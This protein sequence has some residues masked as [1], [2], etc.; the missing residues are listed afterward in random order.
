MKKSILTMT[1]L[2]F[3]MGAMLTGCNSPEQK[4]TNA[5]DDVEAANEALDQ[6]QA[7]YLADMEQFRKEAEAQTISND[8]MIAEFKSRAANEKAAVRAEYD[9]KIAD[10]EESNA[11]MK[12]RMADYRD[13]GSDNWQ[14][15][16]REFSR[17]MNELGEA[18]AN[19]TKSSTK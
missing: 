7:E 10:L 6:A 12:R 11:R 15:F 19:F 1:A 16:K 2:I 4:L 8:Q 5:E 18:I 3:I 17:D 14:E 13:E 9:K